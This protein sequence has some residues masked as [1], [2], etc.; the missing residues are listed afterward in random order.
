MNTRLATKTDVTRFTNFSSHTA[1]G[2]LTKQTIGA[3]G[4]FSSISTSTTSN[5]YLSVANSTAYSGSRNAGIIFHNVT[6]LNYIETDG[7]VKRFGS[8]TGTGTVNANADVSSIVV[9]CSN[10]DT[11]TP[12]PPSYSTSASKASG[13]FNWR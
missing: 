1:A 11:G 2:M 10:T 4:V 8:G 13:K 12:T 6:T 7:V 9:S 3:Q 5:R